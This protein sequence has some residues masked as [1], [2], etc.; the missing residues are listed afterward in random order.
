MND[1]SY[2][3]ALFKAF[4]TQNLVNIPLT[5]VL[6]DSKQFFYV[7]VSLTSAYTANFTALYQNKQIS[8]QYNVV[9]VDALEAQKDLTS[10]N[11]LYGQSYFPYDGFSFTQKNSE[12]PSFQLLF[13]D[14]FQ[15]PSILDLHLG[16]TSEFI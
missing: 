16:P 10:L 11:Q 8:S 9:L 1:P 5:L 15:I 14:K 4:F 13:F 12:Y 6:D 7:D 2:G 3:I